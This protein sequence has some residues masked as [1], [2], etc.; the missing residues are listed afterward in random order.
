MQP[1]KRFTKILNLPKNTK[2]FFESVTDDKH[3]DDKHTD[4]R[5]IKSMIFENKSR[6]CDKEIWAI[7][8]EN[9]THNSD[10]VV[11]AM[12]SDNAVESR[13][14]R[15]QGLRINRSCININDN[16]KLSKRSTSFCNLYLFQ[17]SSKTGGGNDY[18]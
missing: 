6:S 13:K 17:D 10:D 1:T 14:V 18:I 4:D 3:T 9:I 7:P 2:S 15:D 12:E 8:E 11:K 5:H 16:P